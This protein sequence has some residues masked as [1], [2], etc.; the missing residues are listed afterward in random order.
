ML[1]PTSMLKQAIRLLAGVV[2]GAAA[3]EA[4]APWCGVYG[5]LALFFFVQG[6]R[7]LFLE[8]FSISERLGYLR[9]R[10]HVLVHEI[11]CNFIFEYSR[12]IFLSNRKVYRWRSS[13][14]LHD[15]QESVQGTPFPKMCAVIA[16]RLV[17]CSVCDDRGTCILGASTGQEHTAESVFGL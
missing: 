7:S 1:F 5:R 12:Y 4:T 6:C 15:T 13:R 3:A 17:F 9:C 2:A 8:L 14:R 10:Q 11:W 16:G